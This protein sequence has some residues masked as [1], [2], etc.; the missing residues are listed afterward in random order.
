MQPYQPTT[1]QPYQHSKPYLFRVQNQLYIH[2]Y[3]LI[4]PLKIDGD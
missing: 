2:G 1:L 4:H 3:L